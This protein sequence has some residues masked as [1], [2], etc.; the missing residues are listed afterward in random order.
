MKS[1]LD[2]FHGTVGLPW[3]WSIVALTIARPDPA[4]AADGAADPLDAVAA[5][6]RAG[7]EGDPEE[8]QG[9][10]AEAERRADEV[11]QGEPHQPGRVVPAAARAAPGLLRALPHAA[12]LH[13]AHPPGSLAARRPEHHRQGRPRTG[14]ATCCSRSTPARRSRRRY[15]M[16]D[17]DG[18][19]AAQHHDG[20]AA[21]FITV[22]VALPD[23]PGP[24]LGD[25]EPLDGRAGPVTRR[26]VPKT[27]APK[28]VRRA[29][30]AE[31][32]LAHAGEGR[33][34]RRR[35]RRA[36]AEAAQAAGRSRGGSSAR[37][38]AR[39]GERRA[40]PSR[41]P[42]RRSARRSGRRCASSS[43]SRPALDKAARPLPGRLARESAA[44]SASATT[45]ARVVA[46]VDA[47]SAA[48]PPAPRERRERARSARAR[49]ARARRR[50]RSASRARID[51]A[52][53]R[54]R[55]RS[56]P[57]TG[58]D[59]G[60]L[61]GKHGQ[62]IDAVQYARER[63]RLPRRRRAASRSSSTPPATATGAGATLEGIAVRGAERA[64]ARA[65]GSSS[66]R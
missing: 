33:R 4:R 13:E 42:A 25:D 53:G 48:P 39:G 50:R 57:C 3:A 15:F 18:Q 62:T 35:S 36:A 17:D 38:A 7:D 54:R 14:R 45:P 29:R 22:V 20:A 52:R 9:R 37:R 61:I 43:G 12:A 27:P 60:L 5:E 47:A 46:T 11:L 56:P 65:S 24:L 16:G 26:L 55:D 41:R 63:D 59:L 49:A 19:D 30:S 28:L 64:V 23:R 6:A 8:V 21:V 2:F 10:P 34:R 32:Q 40:S 58:G 31:A 1:I 44:C 51:V 66:S